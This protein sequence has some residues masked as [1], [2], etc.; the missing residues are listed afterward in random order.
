MKNFVIR[1]EGD[2]AGAEVVGGGVEGGG[3]G[4]K[5]FRMVSGLLGG[6]GSSLGGFAECRL[7][8]RGRTGLGG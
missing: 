4:L 6:G 8:D 2:G 7:N 3:G 5:R 1:R